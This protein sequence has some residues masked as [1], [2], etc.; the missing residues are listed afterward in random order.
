M[1]YS[2]NKERNDGRVLGVAREYYGSSSYD[3]QVG[4]G[5]EDDDDDDDNNGPHVQ[6]HSGCRRNR[7]VRKSQELDPPFSS[8]CVRDLVS[9]LNS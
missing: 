7:N 3:W 4:G 8:T 2:K 9:H 6:Y 1:V 5:G